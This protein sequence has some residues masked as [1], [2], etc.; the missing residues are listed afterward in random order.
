MPRH[1]ERAPRL[2]IVTPGGLDGRGGIARLTGYVVAAWRAEPDGPRP[3]VLDP[4]GGGGFRRWPLLTLR[5]LARLAVLLAARRIDLVHINLA[6]RGSTWRKAPFLLL[7]RLF[8]VPVVLHL[9]SGRYEGFLRR[10]PPWRRRL[11]GR[12]FG[13]ADRVVVLGSRM[14]AL[15]TDEIGVPAARVAVLAN[16]VPV[17]PAVPLRD[18]AV[19]LVLFLGELSADKGVPDLLRALAAPALSG[20]PWRAVLAGAGDRDAAV[21]LA[22][23]LGIAGRVVLPGWQDDAATR[24]W[25]AQAEIGVLPSRFEGMPMAVLEGMAWGLAM[26]ATP[27][28]EV[29]DLLVEGESGLLVPVGDVQALAEALAR[30]LQDRA[31]RRALQRAARAR[32]ERDFA[33][34]AYARR[35]ARLHRDVAAGVV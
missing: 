15:V 22:A 3:A 13:R 18:D 6:A 35:L 31:L 30:L 33:V 8:A 29:P 19:P 21:R 5:A 11:I 23:E 28:G 9:H 24:A 17:P 34:D 16:A 12:L 26:V 4:W 25:L 27:V 20:L 7:A 10:Q 14:R 2:C 1:P 32:A